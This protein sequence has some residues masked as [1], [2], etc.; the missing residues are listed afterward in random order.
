[1][2]NFWKFK[3][4]LRWQKEDGWT[5]QGWLVLH[6]RVGIEVDSPQDPNG[7]SLGGRGL[8]TNSPTRTPECSYGLN[9]QEDRKGGG[10]PPNNTEWTLCL[11]QFY[12]FIFLEKL[13]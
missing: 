5:K 8:G 12:V 4:S 3:V 7:V 1:M 13:A 6:P 11:V 10:D 9:L 2:K